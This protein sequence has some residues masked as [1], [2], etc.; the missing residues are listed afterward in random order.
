MSTEISN[1]KIYSA[2]W[3][4]EDVCKGCLILEP[5]E[6]EPDPECTIRADGYQDNCP[7]RICL[8][9]GIC[10][11]GCE[12]RDNYRIELDQKRMIKQG[13]WTPCVKIV[14]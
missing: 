3:E 2:V 9:K 11:K 14:K 8:V 12:D 5:P 10:R 4:D 7:C 13:K 1:D 6:P